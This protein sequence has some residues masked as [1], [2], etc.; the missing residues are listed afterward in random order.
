MMT[1]AIQYSSVSGSLP[2]VGYLKGIDLWMV[3]CLGL[4]FLGVLECT[5]LSL[6]ANRL[7][8]HEKDAKGLPEVT[9]RS[10]LVEG[11]KDKTFRCNRIRTI[12]ITNTMW[13]R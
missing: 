7:D 6:L 5:C 2:K 12:C 3:G 1:T 11:I 10:S 9:K 8:Q 4:V 13:K